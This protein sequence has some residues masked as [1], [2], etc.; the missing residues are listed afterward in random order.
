M[1]GVAFGLKQWW[2]K[3]DERPVTT[4]P[5]SDELMQLFRLRREH[6]L[7]RVRVRGQDEVFQ[8][9]LVD[10]DLDK[11]CLLLDE[12]FPN[13]WP[14]ASWLDRRIKVDTMESGFSTA[15]EAKVIGLDQQGRSP[16]LRL[17]IPQ[18]ISTAQRRHNFRV[19]VDETI[20]V[21]ALLSLEGIGKVAADVLD[22]SA[23]G[24]R[25]RV[26]GLYPEL[27]QNFKVQLR[28]ERDKIIQSEL[29]VKNFLMDESDDGVTIV[30]G[31]LSGINPAE[32]RHIERFLIRVQRL[33]R[34]SA[35]QPG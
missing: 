35:M 33:Q 29:T 15:F 17:G 2:Q 18:D 28:L 31:T 14:L 3:V 13:S 22:L 26:I 19:T 27:A 24:V 5:V 6:R 11:Q 8:S 34:Q 9:L 30:G 16:V 21:Q 12:P 20:P 10:I 4:A 1:T 25:L 23:R 32:V 7:L